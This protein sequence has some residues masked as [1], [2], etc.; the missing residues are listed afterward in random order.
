MLVPQTALTKLFLKWRHNVSY[1]V[2]MGF[3]NTVQKK[4]IIQRLKHYTVKMY[5]GMAV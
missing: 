4:F 5:G 2:G 1:K 3:R